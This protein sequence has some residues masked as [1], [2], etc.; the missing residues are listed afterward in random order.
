MKSTPTTPRLRLAFYGDDFTGSTDAMEVL[1]REGVRTVLFL[2]PPSPEDLARFPGLEAVG[3]AGIS[4]TFSPDQMETELRPQFQA[5]KALGA[6]ICHYKM[7]STFDSSPTVG[8]IGRAIDIAQDVFDSPWV[9]MVVGAPRLGRYQVFGQLFAG[10]G[11]DVCRLDRHPTMSRHP[12]TPMH[13]A[14]LLLHLA[15]QTNRSLSLFDILNQTGTSAEIDARLQALLARQSDVI[16]FDVLDE[17]R[18]AQVGRLIW[19]EALRRPGSTLFSA[20]S[21]GLEYALVGHWK[22]QGDLPSSH[23][24]LPATTH[25]V[26][27]VLALSGSC[28]PQTESQIAY[29]L[30]NGY[31]GVDV[32]A[33]RLLDPA[34]GDAVRA[35]V[36]R[37]TVG[38]LK[39]GKSVLL[40]SAR[41]PDDPRIAEL[42]RLS[43]K[44]QGDPQAFGRRLGDHLGRLLRAILSQHRPPRVVV[45]GGD[46]SGFVAQA[47]GI[48]I[49]E[50]IA[51][52]ATA[53]PLCRTHAA[54]PDVDG[55]E[56]LMKGGQVGKREYF[57]SVRTGIF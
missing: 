49:L 18:L 41:G 24:V 38:F 22:R 19:T 8:S 6:H 17:D 23:A 30:A 26:D 2:R 50:P 51:Q 42:Q 20:S 34:T 15:K 31:V 40:Y 54:D 53:S 14:D 36:V 13:E 11:D 47:L 45:A 16:L 12:V 29:A 33:P 27:Q 35:D 10:F 4:R 48:Q 7:C 32:E 1:A 3:V 21:S 28:S 46:T 25:A 56:I 57:V 5:L 52:A 44:K 39:A 43:D 55:L 9:P 37:T